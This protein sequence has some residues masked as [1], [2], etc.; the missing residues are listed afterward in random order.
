VLALTVFVGIYYSILLADGHL[1]WGT[2]G[3]VTRADGGLD[4][5]FNSMAR[6]LLHGRFDVDP[7]IVVQEGFRVR[8]T[9]VAYWGIAFAL[10]R[11]P[12]ALV[13]DGFTLDVTRLS[14]LVAACVALVTKLKTLRMVARQARTNPD[15][16]IVWPLVLAIALS[17]PQIEFLKTS[18]Y[19]EVCLW[20]GALAAIFVY[21]VLAGLLDGFSTRRLCGLALVAGLTLLSRVSAGIAL[22]TAGGLLLST[23]AFPGGGGWTGI[24][25]RMGSRRVLIPL[26]I[27]LGFAVTAGFVNYERWGNPMVFADY[28]LYIE[29]FRHPDRLRRMAEYGLFNL[30]RLPLSL[31]Y[32]LLPV[33][34]FPDGSGNLF[35]AAPMARLFDFAQLPP[36]SFLLTDSL[37]MGFFALAIR[38]MVR[39][40]PGSAL[41]RMQ[42]AAVAAGLSMACLLMLTAISMAFRYRIEFYPL[43]EFGAFLGLY[44]FLRHPTPPRPRHVHVW[45]WAGTA[46]SIVMSH[47][48][49]VLYKLSEKPGLPLA[50]SGFWA[51]YGERLQA[52]FLKLSPGLHGVMAP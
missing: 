41:Q 21:L 37:W 52:L 24:V 49:L 33:W 35:F 12:L 7:A 47:G 39:R 38:G 23:I 3:L 45:L 14:L 5:V 8:G 51:F 17:G 50:Q 22:Y 19:Q 43:L 25:T 11:L 20:A 16:L 34:V 1:P 9:V 44:E 40:R 27:L 4:L 31:L 18:L 2:H 6:N 36:S 32:Y 30:D 29:N 15:G 13:P 28:H 26:S 46:I 48:V 42:I 10:L